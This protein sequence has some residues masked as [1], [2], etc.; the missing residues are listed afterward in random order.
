MKDKHIDQ[1]YN[2][3]MQMAHALRLLKR[4]EEA[5]EVEVWVLALRQELRQELEEEQGGNNVRCK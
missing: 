5:H 4:S 1:L 3:G 2:A